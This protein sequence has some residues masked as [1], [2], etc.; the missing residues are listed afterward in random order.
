MFPNGFP[1]VFTDQLQNKVRLARPP[2]RIVSLV[3]SQTELLF[4]LGLQIQVVGVTKFCHYPQPDVKA[5][6]LAF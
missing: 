4:E 5:R 6:M 3:P 1:L 2:E